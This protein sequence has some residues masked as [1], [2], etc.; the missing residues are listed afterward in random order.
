M[1][2]PM[3]TP[4]PSRPTHAVTAALLALL[5]SA[6]ACAPEP[7]RLQ[8]VEPAAHAASWEAWKA[9]RAA[10]LVAPGRPLSYTGLT[11]LRPGAS[12]VG[13]DSAGDVVLAGRGVPARVGTLVR[14]GAR[15]RFEPAPGVAVTVDSAPA[16]AG[17]LRT[18]ADSAGASRVLVGSAGFRIVKRV[19]SIGVRSWD[20]ERAAVRAFRGVEHFALDPAW[21]VA[22]RLEPLERPRTVAMMTEAGIPEEHAVVGTVHA[23]VGGVPY[24]LV[25]FDGGRPTELFIV[26]ADATSGDESYGFRFLRAARD[27]ASDVVT[28]D[29]NFAYNP[30]CAFSAYT[31]CPLPPRENRL[32]AAVRAGERRYGE[33]EPWERAARVA[34]GGA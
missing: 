10:S 18:D 27:T 4:A 15:V 22:G 34:R 1:S 5:A 25:A 20:A 8:P 12:A 32:R 31:T 17:W 13:G 23:T 2:M 16:A 26:F 24:E 30:D 11:W 21:R 19:D 33:R 3:T 29:F 9:R 14:D 6:A 28:L 7:P